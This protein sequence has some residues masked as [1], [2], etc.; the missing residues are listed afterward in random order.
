MD[1]ITKLENKFTRTELYNY[2]KDNKIE[3]CSKVQKHDLAKI[4]AQHLQRKK[5]LQEIYVEIPQAFFNFD[6]SIFR[7]DKPDQRYNQFKFDE[8]ICPQGERQYFEKGWPTN[9]TLPSGWNMK[10]KSKM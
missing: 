6:D 10:R 1:L 7:T 8:S 2:C 3:K 5:A 4:V 9:G